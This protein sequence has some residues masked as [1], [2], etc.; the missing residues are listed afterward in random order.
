MD[1][2]GEA[3]LVVLKMP[4]E[5]PVTGRIPGRNHGKAPGHLREGERFLPVEKPLGGKALDGPPPL[6]LGRPHGEAR[7]DVVNGQGQAVQFAVAH[8]NLYKHF[9]SRSEFF[10]GSLPELR[11]Q[12]N[13]TAAP[14][15]SL[16]AGHDTA[17]LAPGKIHI[18]V[19]VGLGLHRGKFGT[20]PY[21]PGKELPYPL[22]HQAL[23]PE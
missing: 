19:T 1:I 20:H 5:I 12:R 18:T 6:E 10:S 3:E 13:E 15:H 4:E 22:T 9:H 16:G 2:E 7:L 21:L 17:V 8:H 11:R 23:K 14:Y